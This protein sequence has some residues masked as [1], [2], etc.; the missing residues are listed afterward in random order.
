VAHIVSADERS[1]SVFDLDLLFEN[2]RVCIKEF[3]NKIVFNEAVDILQPAGYRELSANTRYVKKTGLRLTL[4]RAVSNIV[5][6]LEKK[7]SLL[8]SGSDAVETERVCHLL[9]KQYK[10]G[11]DVI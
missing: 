8:C 5:D 11:K 7:D 2:G 3:G 1:Y 9:L 10:R 6:A 4:M